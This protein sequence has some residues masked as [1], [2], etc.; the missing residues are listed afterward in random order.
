MVPSESM[1]PLLL[2]MA[3]VG[4]VSLLGLAASGQFPHEN[5]SPALRSATGATILFGTVLVALICLG[6][7]IAIAWRT[8]PWFAAIIGGGAVVLAAPFALQ[9]L[10]DR[11]VDGRGAL[12]AFAAL[13]VLV[14]LAMVWIALTPVQV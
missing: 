9:P 13:G 4:T 6:I 5:R 8:V 7:G 10:P 11:F 14:T 1:L 12:I 2:F 3:L